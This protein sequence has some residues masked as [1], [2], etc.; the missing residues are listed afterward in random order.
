MNFKKILAG[1]SLTVASAVASAAPWTQTIDFN[2][3]IYIGPAHT[4]THDLTTVGF[5]PGSDFITSFSLTVN[6]K[7]DK[8]DGFLSSEWA[9]ADLPGLLADGIWLSP[10]GSN[11]TGTSLLGAFQLNLNGTLQVTVSSLLGDF[12]L[13]SS[14]LTANGF[15][16]PSSDVPEPGALALVGLGLMGVAL[17]RRQQRAA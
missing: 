5:A 10:I 2:P 12:L 7:D 8:S 16:G 17:R 13:A 3:D 9:F 6:I 4:W 11:S 14:S 1:L 15:D